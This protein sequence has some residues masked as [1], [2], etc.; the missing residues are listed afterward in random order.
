MTCLHGCFS[1]H[2]LYAFHVFYLF[3]VL[4]ACSFVSVIMG[5]IN[6]MV[7]IIIQ[8]SSVHAYQE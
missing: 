7:I 5:Y 1:F 6:H 3:Q 2:A 8:Y 4:R